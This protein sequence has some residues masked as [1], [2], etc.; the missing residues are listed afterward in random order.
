[1]STKFN[2]PKFNKPV[3]LDNVIRSQF[4]NWGRSAV[5]SMIE[6]GKVKVNGKNVSRCSWKV[7]ANDVIEVLDPP[8]E[9]PT[10]P[11]TF[12][13]RWIIA[14][15]GALLAINKP[16]GLLS[17]SNNRGQRVNLLG[18]VRAR[19]GNATLFHRL[20]RDTSG[21]ILFTLPGD[22]QRA[23]NQYLDQAFRTRTVQKEYI[24]FVHAPNQLEQEGE[25]KTLLGSHADRRDMMQVVERGG[26][27]AQ[28]RYE[29]ERAACSKDNID[30]PEQDGPQIQRVSLWPIT[31]RTHQLRVHMLYMSAPIVGDRLYGQHR[32]DQKNGYPR[33]ML[34]AHRIT[35]P[36]A[37]EFSK[38][39]ISA[40]LPIEFS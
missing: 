28:T 30:I 17:E 39:T 31:G 4:P 26:K 25:I 40:P 1:M 6:K 36:A 8:E 22:R 15:D 33:L 9:K 7:R 24:A 16:E 2:V 37:G 35:L 20:D 38:Q 27:M 34:H 18:L 5:Q 13:D 21:V 12:D 32:I 11:D 3:R 19:F 10:Q 29:V 23:L 14:N